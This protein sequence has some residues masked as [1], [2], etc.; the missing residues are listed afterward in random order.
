VA[1]GGDVG[2]DARFQRAAAGDAAAEHFEHAVFAVAH[3][4]DGDAGAGTAD[5]D[6]DFNGR[7]F[8]FLPFALSFSLG[9]AGFAAGAVLFAV[10]SLFSF[11]S[12]FSAGAVLATGFSFAS[13]TGVFSVGAGLAGAFSF[14]GVF[15]ATFS[16]AFSGVFPVD[17]ALAGVFSLFFI[18]QGSN[19]E[20]QL[21]RG[22]GCL[23]GGVFFLPSSRIVRFSILF[24]RLLFAL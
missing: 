7:V 24:Y 6:D 9:A 1:D 18:L 11:G 19:P 5:V 21:C 12:V 17:A 16:A 14:A 2:N 23:K 15:S 22:E 3:F 20:L 8:H 13:F 4:A 10:F